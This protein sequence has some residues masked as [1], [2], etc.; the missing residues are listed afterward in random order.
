M[1]WPGKRIGRLGRADTDQ[2]V[3]AAVLPLVSAATRRMIAVPPL[4]AARIDRRRLAV[5][6]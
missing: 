6:S 3:A 4:S 2:R 1:A 5:K